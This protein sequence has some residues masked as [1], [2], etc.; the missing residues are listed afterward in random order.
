M[1]LKTTVSLCLCPFLITATA[2]SADVPDTID[3]YQE[4]AELVR[5]HD[6]LH[7]VLR[8]SDGAVIDT[9]Y[10]DVG[11]KGGKVHEAIWKWEAQQKRTGKPKQLILTYTNEHG[12]RVRD[13][14]SQTELAL[15]GPLSDDSHPID[16]AERKAR[17]TCATSVE[18]VKLKQLAL[19]AWEAEFDRAYRRLGGDS[20][21]QLKQAREAW[22][23]F[24]DSQMKQIVELYGERGGSIAP[25]LVLQRE[26]ELTRDYANFLKDVL[27]W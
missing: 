3:G 21:T 24:K 1:T 22:G 17:D 8:L 9:A 13:P 18:L 5:G 27:V 23:K 11:G 16:R 4:P 14:D 19:T 12:V 6:P 2:L 10:D 7:I 15:I 26:A 20:N 25:Q